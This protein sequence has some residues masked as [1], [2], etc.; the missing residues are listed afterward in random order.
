[1]LKDKVAIVTGSVRGIGKEIA[2][3]YAE[4]GAKVVINYPMHSMGQEAKDVVLEIESK[5][6]TA[7][8]VCADV[9]SFEESKALIDKTISTYGKLDI[10]VNNAGITK[11]M[12][13]LR[14]TEEE[15][16]KVIS[17]N[18]KGVFNCTKHASRAM[19]KSGGSIINM[20]SVVGIAGNVGQANYAASKAGVIGFTKSVAREFGQK[21]VRV[22]AIAPG[23]IVSDMTDKLSDS[24]K[25]S[26]TGNIPMKRFGSMRDVANTALFLGSDLATY[27]T[28]EVIKVDGGMAM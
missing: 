21:N 5:G 18:L 7:I 27:I 16:D 8:A 6:G 20:A 26:V 23:F 22:N 4:N 9:S 13:L 12:L 2:M 14:M 19:L 25:E 17:V 11:D 3:L 15:F 24:I 28:G 1:M 10:L